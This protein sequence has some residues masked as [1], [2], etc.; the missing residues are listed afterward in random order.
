MKRTEVKGA[1]TLEL[2][3]VTGQKMAK[4]IS[5]DADVTVGELVNG[6]LGKMQLPENDP[7][8]RPLTYQARLEREGRHV[9]DAESVGDALEE[10][11]RLT[12]QP[13]I[14]AG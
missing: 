1:F 9:R 5:V 11:D 13:S 6:V 2:R 8:G 3:D 10:G 4:V 12:L 7:T 14:N